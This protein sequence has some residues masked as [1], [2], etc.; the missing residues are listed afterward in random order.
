MV[1]LVLEA[2][3]SGLL[4]IMSIFPCLREGYWA[5]PKRAE[6]LTLASLLKQM[7]FVLVYL[8]LAGL[9]EA[10]TDPQW[11]NSHLQEMN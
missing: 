10:R 5:E 4:F 9:S 7:D 1:P 3:R 2:K 6:T 11:G 8:T